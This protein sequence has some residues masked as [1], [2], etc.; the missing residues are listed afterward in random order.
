MSDSHMW[1][2][3]GEHIDEEL[4]RAHDRYWRIARLTKARLARNKDEEEEELDKNSCLGK[5]ALDW[6]EIVESRDALL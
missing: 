2:L 4:T 6:E 1:R 3:R 5:M